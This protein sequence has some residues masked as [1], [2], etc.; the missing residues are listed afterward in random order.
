MPY[1]VIPKR[2][3]ISRGCKTAYI[4]EGEGG[5]LLVKLP[6]KKRQTVS[7]DK[8]RRIYKVIH[9]RGDTW[10]IEVYD[11]NL[12][13]ERVVEDLSRLPQKIQKKINE[14]FKT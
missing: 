12:N 13:I 7:L 11:K 6:S 3:K 8:V 1:L 2:H 5:E 14:I 4:L 10:R 9:I